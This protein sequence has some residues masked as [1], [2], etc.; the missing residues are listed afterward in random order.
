[1]GMPVF[2]Q[3]TLNV[4]GCSCVA[5]GDARPGG[6]TEGAHR[7]ERQVPAGTAYHDTGSQLARVYNRLDFL[8][9]GGGG[10]R[11]G[12]KGK[13]QVCGMFR[14]MLR[15]LMSASSHAGVTGQVPSG[16]QVLCWSWM[17]FV[18]LY[19]C[20]C[21]CVRVWQSTKMILKFRE[22]HIS[23]LEKVGKDNLGEEAVL[24]DDTNVRSL[25]VTPLVR[26]L[27]CYRVAGV[28]VTGD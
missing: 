3:A 23:N 16:S 22:S 12:G 2:V 8:Y 6:E 14:C 1:M 21:G 10:V 4:C 18:C 5:I 19:S 20:K 17:F 27:P 11:E 26:I 25:E 9:G 13:E 24:Q 15:H 28:S 7:E